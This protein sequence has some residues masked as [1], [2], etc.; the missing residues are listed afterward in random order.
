MDIDAG[1]GGV[2]GAAIASILDWFDRQ[3]VSNMNVKIEK[4][5][6]KIEAIEKNQDSAIL[7]MRDMNKEV[8]KKLDV[9]LTVV[10]Q[11]QG[12]HGQNVR[13]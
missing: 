4:Q 2:I 7:E 11:I 6:T 13:K 8:N 5:E 1:I 3:K 10:G 12:A 9:L